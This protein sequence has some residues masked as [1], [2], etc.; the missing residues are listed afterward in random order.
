MK[1]N[2]I[3][4]DWKLKTICYGWSQNEVK[5]SKENVRWQFSF[6]FPDNL[7]RYRRNV[8]FWHIPNALKTN[9]HTHTHT[10]DH[11]HCLLFALKVENLSKDS[12]LRTQSIFLLFSI[13]NNQRHSFRVLW[14]FRLIV[15]HSHLHSEIEHL[16]KKR[17][18]K[19]EKI[20][21]LHRRNG[22]LLPMV[23]LMKRKCSLIL[24]HW[25]PRFS[26]FTNFFCRLQI[27]NTPL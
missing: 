2:I 16:R 4:D 13:N 1:R 12:I 5:T 10:H 9:Q 25:K 18:E 22:F 24:N 19:I 7:S 11:P 15:T 20:Y 21:K 17:M 8:W 6:E 26:M 27:E 14:H 3:F 23:S